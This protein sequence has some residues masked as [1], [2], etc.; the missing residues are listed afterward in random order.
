MERALDTRSSSGNPRDCGRH[1]KLEKGTPARWCGQHGYDCWARYNP[2]TY[3]QASMIVDALLR[4]EPEPDVSNPPPEL[5][6]ECR[7]ELLAEGYE[8][9]EG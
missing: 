8:L 3:A 2:V 9:E 6:E 4:R 7:Q 1:L 5:V